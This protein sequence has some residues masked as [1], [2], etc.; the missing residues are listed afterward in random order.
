MAIIDG[1][2]KPRARRPNTAPT[3]AD[4]D[5]GW[6]RIMEIARPLGLIVQGYGGTVTMA[7]P[8]RQRRLGVRGRVL[9][10]HNMEENP[11]NE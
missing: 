6:E 7:T 11:A 5:A 10:A 3:D 2:G 4:A 9:R 8:Y 1:P